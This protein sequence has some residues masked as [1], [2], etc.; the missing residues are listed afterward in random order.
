[1]SAKSMTNINVNNYKNIDRFI[2][3]KT[4]GMSIIITILWFSFIF[5]LYSIYY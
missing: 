3:I 4:K 1:M 5:S 2:I